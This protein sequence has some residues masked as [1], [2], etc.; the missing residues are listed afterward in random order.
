MTEYKNIKVHVVAQVM[1]WYGTDWMHLTDS[2][3][4]PK[5]WSKREPFTHEWK[6]FSTAVSL[7][8]CDEM[9]EYMMNKRQAALYLGMPLSIIE[10]AASVAF[11]LKDDTG[12]TIVRNKVLTLIKEHNGRFYTSQSA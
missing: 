6:A 11:H 3:L 2:V 12:F 10:M 5:D 1:Q 7:L 8:M 4:E 9:R